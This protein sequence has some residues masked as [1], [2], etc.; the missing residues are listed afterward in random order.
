M[1]PYQ[2]SLEELHTKRTV[3]NWLGELHTGHHF[4]SAVCNSFFRFSGRFFE[5]KSDNELRTARL[6]VTQKSPVTHRDRVT[7]TRL[8]GRDVFLC[9][10]RFWL[11]ASGV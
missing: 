3:C 6:C 10:T 2:S 7:H 1:I 5:E 4:L 8:K 11:C 9:V